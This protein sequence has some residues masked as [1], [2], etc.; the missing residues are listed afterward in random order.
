MGVPIP[1]G[2]RCP[3][4]SS[5]KGRHCLATLQKK[6]ETGTTVQTRGDPTLFVHPHKVQQVTG[7]YEV[8]E[9][10][11][12]LCGC[13]FSTCAFLRFYCSSSCGWCAF[14]VIS[15]LLVYHR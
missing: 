13:V 4:V 1:R 2:L 14:T 8:G 9:S 7:K 15:H 5:S 11:G 12:T 10:L 6:T 3:I